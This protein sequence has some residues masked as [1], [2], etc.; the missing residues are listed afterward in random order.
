MEWGVQR[1]L[2]VFVP[3]KVQLWL[4]SQQWVRAP[5]ELVAEVFLLLADVAGELIS[6]NK[7]V[8]SRNGCYELIGNRI[9]YSTP[10]ESSPI[11]VA[12]RDLEMD[13]HANLLSIHLSL[14]EDVPDLVLATRRGL[15]ET[16]DD[17]APAVECYRL[18]SVDLFG[19][20]GRE[21]LDQS[22]ES[23]ILV[24][25]LATRRIMIS[26]LLFRPD[27]PHAAQYAGPSGR[28]LHLTSLKCQGCDRPCQ[29]L[30]R[31]A[32][33]TADGAGEY[34]LHINAGD[35]YEWGRLTAAS[36]AQTAF[37]LIGAVA[38]RLDHLDLAMQDPVSAVH[39]FA[40]DPYAY[41]A[42]LLGGRRCRYDDILMAIVAPLSDF[43]TE[44]SST[45]AVIGEHLSESL[46]TIS[47]T[48]LTTTRW[49]PFPTRGVPE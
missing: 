47:A 49:L 24:P 10:W 42:T 34:T 32:V 23:R 12:L 30:Y 15:L 27:G 16:P 7:I 18:Q 46:R 37:L 2:G 4:P 41:A 11:L 20:P 17:I 19:L 38:G 26:S 25:F 13:N 33:D 9:W 45:D 3:S 48:A 8:T 40:S 14:R 43:V 44:A 5:N 31:S 6:A 29:A 21:A 28:T 22:F 35:D 36:L 1:E 39:G